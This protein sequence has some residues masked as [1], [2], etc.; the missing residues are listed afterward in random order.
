MLGLGIGLHRVAPGGDI[1]GPVV[2]FETTNVSDWSPSAVTFQVSAFGN[3]ETGGQ[4]ID[5]RE[6]T[7]NGT[8]GLSK[9]IP[10]EEGKLYRIRVLVRGLNETVMAIVSGV[11]GGSHYLYVDLTTGADLLSAGFSNLNWQS[12]GGGWCVVEVDVEVPS[13]GTPDMYLG[14]SKPGP[15]PVFV[16]AVTDGITVG[17]V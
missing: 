16:G 13:I 1:P 15:N 5:A 7:D 11:G 6:T 14:I 4:G 2:V 10:F 17:S 8:H 12:I 9:A 3:P